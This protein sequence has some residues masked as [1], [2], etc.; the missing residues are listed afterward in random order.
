MNSVNDPLEKSGALFSRG[1]TKAYSACPWSASGPGCTGAS[2]TRKGYRAARTPRN[3]RKTHP[4]GKWHARYRKSTPVPA[5]GPRCRSPALPAWPISGISA[6]SA[7]WLTKEL[8][9]LPRGV[10]VRL[11]DA[12]AARPRAAAS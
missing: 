6:R 3:G 1:V 7:D 2:A 12:H 11:R 4:P 10:S 9:W 8:S 5:L